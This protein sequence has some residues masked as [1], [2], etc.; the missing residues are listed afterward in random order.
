MIFQAPGPGT[1][2][3]TDAS[4]YKQRQPQYSMTARNE[5]PGDGTRKPG[6]GAYRPEKVSKPFF[7]F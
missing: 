4:T 7:L 2:K 5:L 3:V 6:P 1:Y